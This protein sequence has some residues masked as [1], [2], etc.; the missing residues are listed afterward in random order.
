MNETEQR[1]ERLVKREMRRKREENRAGL[2]SFSFAVVLAAL[3]FI[4]AIHALAFGIGVVLGALR[5]LG[6]FP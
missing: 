2:V 4:C 1:I 3:I 6:V 5:W